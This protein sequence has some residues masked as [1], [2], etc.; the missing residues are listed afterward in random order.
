MVPKEKE[1]SSFDFLSLGWMINTSISFDSHM[2]S[3]MDK[4]WPIDHHP[5]FDID[6]LPVRTEQETIF[7]IG[8]PIP[9][10]FF[11]DHS[12]WPF[13]MKLLCKRLFISLQFLSRE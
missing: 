12:N 7:H 9:E 13:F 5:G 1:D 11:P 6:I 2:I 10:W 8:E 4:P 3:H